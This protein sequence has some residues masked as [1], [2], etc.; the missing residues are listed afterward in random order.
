MC[1][2][3]WTSA[4]KVLE[5]IFYLLKEIISLFQK[6]NKKE[7]K[8]LLKIKNDIKFIFSIGFLQVYPLLFYFSSL[9][10]YVQEEHLSC[11]DAIIVVEHFLSKIKK[12]I[13]MYQIHESGKDLYKLIKKKLILNKNVQMF[14]LASLMCPDGII[15]YRQIMSKIN[16]IFDIEEENES[17]FHCIN[18]ELSILI[19]EKNR[20]ISIDEYKNNE[21]KKFIE[22]LAKSYL[23]RYKNTKSAAN[24]SSQ[25]QLD[26]HH[27][28]SVNINDTLD[29]GTL[30]NDMLDNDSDTLPMTI[31]LNNAD[32]S[33]EEHHLSN[34]NKDVLSKEKKNSINDNDEIL[35]QIFKENNLVFSLD[36]DK[37]EAYVVDN[38]DASGDILIPQKIIYEKHKFPVVCIKEGSF[39]NSTKIRS[40][41]LPVDSKV[42]KIEKNAFADSSIESIFI[43]SSVTCL[44]EGWCK[45]TSKLKKVKIMPKNKYFICFDNDMILGKS[46]IQ[47]QNYDIILFVNRDIKKIKIPSF[48]KII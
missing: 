45:G 1:V 24:K 7:I 30:D 22:I 5:T 4:F 37:N 34:A 48:V 46:D 33:C 40:I 6:A 21:Y 14:Q 31:N 23:S 32:E 25:K 15:R 26:L 36:F 43:S 8:L 20:M 41:H 17:Y 47:S 42:E 27:F 29:N 38:D 28:Y 18:E 12:N 2:T 44:S 11:V 13:E 10:E 9:M 16:K 39:Q 19:K 3:R 35:P